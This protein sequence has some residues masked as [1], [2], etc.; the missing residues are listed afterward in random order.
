MDFE[1]DKSWDNLESVLALKLT[2]KEAWKK[3]IDFHELTQPKPYW[4]SLIQLDLEG[5]QLELKNWIENLI[6]SSPLPNNVCAL[7]V[8]ILKFDN[9]GEVLPAIYLVGCNTFQEDEIDWAVDPIYVPEDKYACPAVLLKID[10]IIRN[11]EDNYEFLDWIL[12]LAYCSLTLDEI[13]RVQLDKKLLLNGQ[14]K[15]NFATGHDDGDFFVLSNI[16]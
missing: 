1:H 15:L 10:Q 13:V 9:D 7:W 6:E 5:E 4:S 14:A 8:G 3:I 16:E 11:D 2:V 12:P